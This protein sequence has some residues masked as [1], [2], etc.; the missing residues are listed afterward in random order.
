L[1]ALGGM[2]A[3]EDLRTQRLLRITAIAVGSLAYW[4][5]LFWGSSLDPRLLTRWFFFPT[6]PFPQLIF[7]IAGALVYRRRESL[8]T[9]LWRRLAGCQALLL[10]VKDYP[11][12]TS[13]FTGKLFDYIG[14]RIPILGLVPEKGV[15]AEVIKQAGAWFTFGEEKIG[16]GREN[17]LKT[18]KENKQ[19]FQKIL[20]LVREK[21]SDAQET[22]K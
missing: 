13:I 22:E 18:F 3:S 20:D 4:R 10:I 2:D 17:C 1:G 19:L 14:A 21:S 11:G 9:P 16:Q 6:D 5:L 8:R 15:A 7:L 12:N